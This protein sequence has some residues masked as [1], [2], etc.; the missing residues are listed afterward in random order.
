MPA[1]RPV[2]AWRQHPAATTSGGNTMGDTDLR[3]YLSV[4]LRRLPL[5][6]A[7][8]ALLT[9]VGLV[10]AYLMPPVYRASARILVDPP[11]IPADMARPTVQVNPVEQLQIIQQDITTREHM[12]DLARRLDIYGARGAQLSETD[13]VD[14]LR[15]RTAFEQ[16]EM[17]RPR[18]GQGA[19]VF[20]VSFTA[21][22]P[23]LA[24]RVVNELVAFILDRNIGLRTGKAEDT[25]Q[26]FDNEVLRL[27]AELARREQAVLEFR[28]A[29]KGALPDS[30]DFRRTQQGNQQE[31]LLLLEREE[32][33]LRVRR[34]NLERMFEATGR[35]AGAGPLSPE[36]ELLR[37]M[38][39]TLTEQLSL[40][41]SDSPNIVA[42]RQ[43]IAA[44]QAD[45][46]AGDEA[47]E[48]AAEAVAGPSEFD[49]QLADIDERL[50]FIER[51]KTAISR[52]VDDLARSIDATPQNETR[53]NALERD[54]D[55]IRAQYNAAV[56][57]LAE[58]STGEQIELRSKAGRFSV[59]EAATPPQDRVSPNR[60]RIAGAGLAA[61]IVS[62]LG[63]IVLLELAN[64]SIRRPAELAGLLE[65]P[66]LATIPY[67]W[68][69]GERTA[70]NRRL[71]LGAGA[72]AGAALVLAVAIQ[73]YRSPLAT[74]FETLIVSIDSN[75]LM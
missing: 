50:H 18:N 64:R 45:I 9:G 7:I 40:F 10:I 14:N 27:D 46:R 52:S 19:T 38:K 60:R 73:H 67:I 57:K 68:L 20:S 3:F 72:A 17:E 58:A 29:N 53:L 5:L 32:S 66:P 63:L 37:D 44:L 28:N 43:R 26:F 62:G 56:L 75:R 36:Q 24:A 4:L 22:E 54:R 47:G 69:A 49:L 33:A 30:I 48:K 51:E 8:A 55:N 42:L 13:I 34:N 6:L 31:R 25:A 41:S 59:V 12:L 35:I 61:G 65:A 21:R 23:E 74:A 71:L 39:R 2:S 70:R 11:Q 16:V 15:A 1:L